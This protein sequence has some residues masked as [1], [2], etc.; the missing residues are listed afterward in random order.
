[1][2]CH[3]HFLYATNQFI[4]SFTSIFDMNQ[5]ACKPNCIIILTCFFFNLFTL[6]SSRVNAQEKRL[7]QARFKNYVKSNSTVKVQTVDGQKIQRST[8][9]SVSNITVPDTG[10]KV[11]VY[12]DRVAKLDLGSLKLYNEVTDGKLPDGDVK[13][14]PE[15]HVESSD[16]HA[17][18]IT[19][20]VIFTMKQ[21]L[22][23]DADLNKF[24][25]KLGFLLMSDS[26]NAIS[27][28]EPVN[29]E[30]RS[31]EIKSITP[32]KLTIDHLSIPSTDIDLLADHVTDSISVRVATVSNPQ[33]YIAFLK[34]H[35]VLEISSNRKSIQGLGIQETEINVR[36][37]GSKSSDSVK[38]VFSAEKGTIKPSSVNL[39]YNEPAK[40]LLRSEGLGKSKITAS[41]SQSNS[42]PLVFDFNFPL[43]FL[44][45]SLFGG[46][47]GGFVKYFTSDK[48]KSLQ[49]IVIVAILTGLIVA[50][51]YYGLGISLIGVKIS[52]ILNEIAVFALSALGAIFGISSLKTGSNE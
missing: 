35:P 45:A 40:V 22:F 42:N 15:I 46:L 31:D 26:D 39:K 13:V 17:G 27:I 2:R 33:G 19:Y 32:D 10:K 49:K 44:L 7:N 9:T 6:D 14:I 5:Y 25:G 23:F 30:V 11:I 37:Y 21:P 3:I 50:A 4:P 48:E 47:L 36:I 20:R 29:I 38:V 12:Q 43:Y 1:M 41:S 8:E 34:V 51:V 24:S 18:A 28:K 16:D 52:A